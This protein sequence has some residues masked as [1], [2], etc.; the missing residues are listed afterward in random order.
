MFQLKTFLRYLV[1]YKLYTAVTIFGFAI[2]LTFIIL[3]TV[4]I[5]NEL[6]VDD[7]HVNKERIFRIE[8]GEYTDFSPPIAEDIK[9]STPEIED[10]TR[11]LDDSGIITTV[12]DQK[13]KVDFLGVDTSFFKIFSFSLVEGDS[14]DVL[15]SSNSIV[16]SRSLATKL[17]GTNSAM[18]QEVVI[19]KKHKFMVTGIMDDF[20]LNTHFKKTDAFINFKAFNDVYDFG[21][22]LNSYGFGAISI[23][24]LAKPNTD[25]PSKASGV[26][27]TYKKHFEEQG[28]SKN[29]MFTPLEDLYFSQ[30]QGHGT[31]NNSKSFITVL[32]VIVLLILIL[33]VSNYV[34]LTMAQS[35][36]R[37]REVA[38]KKLLGGTKR[39]L[40][41]Q[42]IKES[43]LICFI[44]IVL[45][46]LLAKLAEPGFNSLL[47]TELNLDD[48]ITFLNVPVLIGVFC[49]IGIVSGLL[50]AI[51]ITSFKPLEVVKGSFRTKSKGIYS[52]VFITFQY[53]VTIAL[54]ACSWL[55]MKQTN[56]LRS[57][58]LGFSKD[59]LVHI[60]YLGSNE[61]KKT[62][63]NALQKLPGVQDVSITWGSP[64]D[65]G[66][67]LSFDFKGKEISFQEFAVDSSFFNVFNLQIKP[68]DNA[69]SK[70]GVYINET[71]LKILEFESKPTA[72]MPYDTAFPI[73][74]VVNDFNFNELS[75]S[76]GP[77][78][79]FQQK[80]D[81]YTSNIFLK[82]SGSNPFETISKIKSAYA[83]LIENAPFDVVFVDDAINEWYIKEEKTGKIIGY[84]T[85][86]SFVISFMG[87]LAMSIFFMQQRRKE[88]SI[89]KVNG[90]TITQILSLLNK[91]FVK[92]VG[93]AFIIAV[94][95]AWYAMSKWL[96][97]FAYKTT[98][99][100]W[101]FALAGFAAL[102]IALLTVSWQSFRA[103]VANPVE[104]LRDE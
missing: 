42:F 20:P 83:P 25:L 99:S 44:A 12:S 33:A 36:L 96:E 89:R 17:F 55:V 88:I 101:I 60:E 91:D 75:Q 87:I 81:S 41:S 40:F 16:I 63:K 4:Y 39:G 38:I 82:I 35:T 90:A 6:K 80:K 103:A 29:F 27:E 34:N 54:L 51:K 2:S 98:M 71:A 64:L 70:D 19:D 18:G 28:Y 77:I 43:I 57:H 79:L 7:F 47:D 66:S 93:L 104:S 11:V 65:G 48:N 37:G 86:L 10:F 76:I 5:Q 32:S 67:N 9:N 74:G 94:P 97:G 31:K 61:Q 52:K 13:F 46:L 68:T 23:Y 62:I 92:W 84:F 1:K 100:W 78:V 15:L 53:T 14:T 21:D 58:D 24:Y 59:N 56:F 72:F 49:L 73:L 85:L 26:Y 8:D 50:P 45:S 3:L 69:Y 30:K 102:A 95:I 22:I